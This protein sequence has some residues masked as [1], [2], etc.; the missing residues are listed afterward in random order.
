MSREAEG[1]V[2]V[3]VMVIGDSAQHRVRNVLMLILIEYPFCL[4]GQYNMCK[5]YR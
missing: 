2:A 4:F 3:S 5:C 1:R